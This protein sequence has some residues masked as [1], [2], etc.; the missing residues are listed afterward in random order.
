M[1]LFIQLFLAITLIFGLSNCNSTKPE[2]YQF[3]KETPFNIK[4]ATYQEWVA[5]VRGGG[6]GITITLFMDD[7]DASK[8]KID[9]IYFRNYKASLLKRGEDYIANIKTK[10]NVHEDIIIHKNPEKEYGNMA[11]VMNKKNSF[12]LSNEEAVICFKENNRH[13]YFKI[14][15]TKAP[16]ILYQ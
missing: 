13:K 14:K 2:V 12:D 3:Q 8:I 9:S 10:V 4:K 7:F 6:S 5:G 15:L 11:P 16:V 1:K